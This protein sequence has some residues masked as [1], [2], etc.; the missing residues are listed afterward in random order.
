MKNAIYSIVDYKTRISRTKFLCLLLLY[1]SILL[2]GSNL[3]I[4]WDGFLGGFGEG[5]FVLS[6][7]LM[8][9]VK[10]RRLH[11]LDFNGLTLLLTLI[12]FFAVI[13]MGFM[14]FFP[15][16]KSENRYGPSPKKAGL[17][18]YIISIIF[19]IS[20]ILLYV[21]NPKQKI[22]W[23]PY[24]TPYYSIKFPGTPTTEFPTNNCAR[25]KKL[26]FDKSLGFDKYILFADYQD[27]H[28]CSKKEIEKIYGVENL[29]S[30]FIVE[31]KDLVG[32]INELPME[33]ITVVS[34]RNRKIKNY[35]S[36]ELVF[37]STINDR[38]IFGKAI[39]FYFSN[40]YIEVWAL[41]GRPYED[42]KKIIDNFLNSFQLIS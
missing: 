31:A 32:V 13:I 4:N 39:I 18:E 17:K 15:G 33:N 5:L 37:K 19:V 2:F 35:L 21:F 30:L 16:E 12:P 23:K 3:L 25:G 22:E 10:I 14:L 29:E 38:Q 26:I 9:C 20:V 40:V 8:I 42:T 1:F 7:I 24:K 34:S 11:D 41:Q 36:R 27:F 6:V 28:N